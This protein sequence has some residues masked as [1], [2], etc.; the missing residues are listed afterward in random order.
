MSKL[1]DLRY[2]LTIT[3]GVRD[4]SQFHVKGAVTSVNWDHLSET[5]SKG[6][7]ALS[8]NDLDSVSTKLPSAPSQL[9]L[10]SDLSRSPY[11]KDFDR[12]GLG[13]V[14]FMSRNRGPLRHTTI[15]TSF[16]VCPRYVLY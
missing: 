15:N 8:S 9:K 11:C 12:V 5:K 1:I 7:R 13:S 10:L 2:P 4:Q 14:N 3:V 16:T 6:K